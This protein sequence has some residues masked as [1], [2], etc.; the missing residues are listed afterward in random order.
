MYRG[1]LVLLLLPVAG[2]ASDNRFPPVSQQVQ[3]NQNPAQYVF[4]AGDLHAESQNNGLT[5]HWI[6][7]DGVRK[8]WDMKPELY[9]DQVACPDEFVR[10]E[11]SSFPCY[12]KCIFSPPIVQLYD[13]K[14][15]KL[16]FSLFLDVGHNVPHSVFLA[17]LNSKK[18]STLFQAD[19]S[20]GLGNFALS[21]SDVFLAYLASWHGSACEGG[22]ILNVFD[23]KTRSFVKPLVKQTANSV[24]RKYVVYDSI[25][26]LSNSKL[27]LKGRSYNCNPN[28][29]NQT[30]IEAIAILPT[31]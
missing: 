3:S 27:R 21:P 9:Q 11:D 31:N 22:R 24:L 7:E 23:L 6:S 4:D 25:D 26:W 14:D 12:G 8:S 19:Y 2:F 17:D 13:S 28:V 16:Y 18:V 30:R 15:K 1:F 10:C 20:S 5:I 29:S